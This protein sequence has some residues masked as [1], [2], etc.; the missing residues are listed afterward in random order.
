MLALVGDPEQEYGEVVGD[1][2]RCNGHRV[3]LAV[4]ADSFHGFLERSS[5]DLVVVSASLVPD[6]LAWTVKRIRDSYGAPVVVTFENENSTKVAACFAAGADYCARKPFHPSEFAARIDAIMRR[7]RRWSET[8]DLNDGIGDLSRGMRLDPIARS[9]FFNGVD[10]RCSVTE[11]LTIHAMW[12]A[13]GQIVPYAAINHRVWGYSDMRDGSLLKGHI[14][15]LRSKFRAAGYESDPI[16]TV[17]GVGYGLRITQN[18]EQLIM[19]GA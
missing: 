4:S 5:A 19:R 17:Y 1:V 12:E 3:V 18:D 15:A 7:Y 10:I 13:S 8:V 2:L 16:R 11:Y 9:V 6:S 14:S